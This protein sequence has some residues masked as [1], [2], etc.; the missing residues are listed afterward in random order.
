M[1]AAACRLTGAEYAA[2]GVL[3]SLPLVVLR[4]WALLATGALV[5]GMLAGDA[6]MYR[7]VL[8]RRKMTVPHV[9]TTLF[10]SSFLASA[11]RRR[12]IAAAPSRSSA[13]V[14]RASSFQAGR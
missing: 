2:L 10:R 12:A 6:A 7:Y 1:T 11:E 8:R 3:A 9:M 4:P 13:V 14:A 5:A